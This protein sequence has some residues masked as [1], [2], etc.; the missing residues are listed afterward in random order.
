MAVDWN[1]L[2]MRAGK[3]SFIRFVI[4]AHFDPAALPEIVMGLRRQLDAG[5]SLRYQRFPSDEFLPHIGRHLDLGATAID[6]DRLLGSFWEVTGL[7]MD[8]MTLP[9]DGWTCSIRGADERSKAGIPFAIAAPQLAIFR[10]GIA[11]VSVEVRPVRDDPRDW[12][13]LAHFM[14]FMTPGRERP[15]SHPD[16]P[17]GATIS[18]LLEATAS[19]VRLAHDRPFDVLVDDV[20]TGDRAALSLGAF[21]VSECMIYGSVYLDGA[22]TEQMAEL[23]ERARSGFHSKQGDSVVNP[24]ALG[25]EHQHRLAYQ[26]GQT[27]ELG[28]SASVFVGFDMP[29]SQFSAQNLPAHLR[30]VYFVLFELV[31]AQRLALSTL[32]DDVF[33]VVA[34][35]TSRQ[36]VLKLAD[37]LDHIV[38]LDRQLLDFTGSSSFLQVTHQHHHHWYYSKLRELVQVENFYREVK[39]E[40]ATLR[41]YVSSLV[42]REEDRRA[43]VLQIAVTAMSAIFVPAGVLLTLFQ[44]QIPRWP[45]LHELSPMAS[46][47]IT[48]F[49]LGI[50]STVLW[51]M[52]ALLRRRGRSRR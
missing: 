19:V 48:L 38:E 10:S 41:F 9:F 16:V 52:S 18:S 26:E 24:S 34:S 7:A 8:G 4:P 14:R 37:I 31:H 36:G 51:S 46:T 28:L 42:Q 30:E 1:Q 47:L 49:I 32:S 11:F 15:L 22:P 27:F 50:T 43:N 20:G 3:G 25:S 33:E 44:P 40:V 29:D 6:A 35:A 45:G 17:N 21:T 2:S 13:D 39:D 23:R 12:F 5:G